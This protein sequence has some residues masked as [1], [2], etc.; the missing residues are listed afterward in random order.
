MNLQKPKKEKEKGREKL[1]Y[2]V[3]SASGMIIVKE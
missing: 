3:P 1:R 2:T